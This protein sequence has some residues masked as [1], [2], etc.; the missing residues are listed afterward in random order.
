[1]QGWESGR[2]AQFSVDLLEEG[3]HHAGRM[4]AENQEEVED[5]TFGK[6]NSVSVGSGDL[7][8]GFPP[9]DR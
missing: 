5:L 8:W 2:R 7:H 9:V 3:G 6:K 4:G 1:M